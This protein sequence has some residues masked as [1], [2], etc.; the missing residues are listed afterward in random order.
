MPEEYG[1]KES[2][3]VLEAMGDSSVLCFEGV[4][5]VKALADGASVAEKAQAFAQAIAA[6]V[7]THPKY[8]DDFKKAFDQI[9]L[10]P[11]EIRDLSFGEV[12]E[13]ATASGRIMLRCTNEVKAG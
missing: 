2:V 4:K 3:E 13:L 10:V 7:M 5:A 11:K 12:I 9:E 1:I 6:K 8:M